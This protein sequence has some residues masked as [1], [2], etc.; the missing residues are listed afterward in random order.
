MNW[1]YPEMH[2]MAIDLL[3]PDTAIRPNGPLSPDEAASDGLADAEA[4]LDAY[5]AAVVA[6]AEKVGPAVVHIASVRRG[7]AQTP[8]GLVPFEAPGNG[9]GVIIAPD[10]YILT[11]S[12]V[13]LDATRLEVT[14]A[15]GR[16]FPARLVGDDPT[17]DL[18]VIR[19]DASGLP[20]ATLG[21]SERLRAGQLVIAIGNPFGF[22]ATITAGVVSASRHVKISQRRSPGRARARRAARSKRCRRAALRLP[23]RWA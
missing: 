1:S 4:V 22:Q 9:S 21:D 11:N 10:G 20:V 2:L 19:A 18:A 6:V 17:T 5:S 23:T 7:T 12:H 16:S 3:E 14:L 13:V 15:D 8:R